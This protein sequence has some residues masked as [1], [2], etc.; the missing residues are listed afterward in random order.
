M[1]LELLIDA[2]I[3]EIRV[4]LM[5]GD[6]PVELALYRESSGPFP[7]EELAGRVTKIMAETDAAFIDIAGATALL[8]YRRARKIPTASG[9]PPRSIAD[10]VTEGEA[11][12]VRIHREADPQDHKAAIC[13]L[14]ARGGA[15]SAEPDFTGRILALALR[16]AERL[17]VGQITIEGAEAFRAAKRLAKNTS[18]EHWPGAGSLF[19]D[20]GVE[21]AIEEAMMVRIPLPSRGSIRIDETAALT[22]IDVDTAA[23]HGPHHGT[24][25][26]ELV[27]LQT[28]LEAAEKIAWALRFLGIGGLIVIDSIDMKRKKDRTALIDALDQA[29]SADPTPTEHTGVSRFGLVELSRAK[30]G[31]SIRQKLLG[32]TTQRYHREQSAE[33]AALAL[34]RLA[35][36]AGKAPG[37]GDLILSAPQNVIS[38][39]EARSTLTETLARRT[40]RR[41]VTKPSQREIGA[42][43][44][45][46]E[47]SS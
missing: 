9:K 17:G 4:A 23:A 12:T 11:V 15:D 19:E 27:R 47:K 39:L 1:T 35:G 28:N 2:G 24:G 14:L 18:V 46:G 33:A 3:G 29:L 41:V 25:N 44:A 22:A 13:N 30:T 42:H 36:R 32:G 8:P 38:W 7:G 40:R 45:T 6:R 37:P 10:C 34:L 21:E 31:P 5:D 16:R 26:A 43:L 20:R